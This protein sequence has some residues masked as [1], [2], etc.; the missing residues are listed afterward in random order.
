[1]EVFIS[2]AEECIP[3]C[4]NNKI[5]EAIGLGGVALRSF[6]K[7]LAVSDLLQFGQL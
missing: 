5:E 2:M 7:Q 4:F 3:T 6:N 1:M